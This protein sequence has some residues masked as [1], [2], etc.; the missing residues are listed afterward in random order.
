MK[1]YKFKAMSDQFHPPQPDLPE[2]M[3]AQK[4]LDVDDTVTVSVKTKADKEIL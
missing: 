1:I 3:Q 4:E 2:M